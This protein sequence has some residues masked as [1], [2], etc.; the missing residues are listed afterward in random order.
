MLGSLIVSLLSGCVRT[1]L[2]LVD[3]TVP[4]PES[5]DSYYLV[6]P[7]QG[8]SCAFQL[9]FIIPIGNN[10]LWKT[11]EKVT[12]A[13]ADGLIDVSVDTS[14]GYTPLGSINC[15]QIRGL[16]VRFADPP[17]GYGPVVRAAP[18]PAI[19]PVSGAPA[20]TPQK[21][22][23][24]G[25]TLEST[26]SDAVAQAH[27]GGTFRQGIGPGVRALVPVMHASLISE[28]EFL[29]VGAGADFVLTNNRSVLVPIQ[30]RYQVNDMIGDG[31]DA[32]LMGELGLR[33]DTNGRGF[34]GGV[35]GGVTYSFSDRA[36]AMVELG[37]PAVRAG[38][39]V[40]M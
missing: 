38:V 26:R 15:T 12:P 36:S 17:A 40:D 16:A 5:T 27:L 24:F 22:E 37:F 30:A 23:A 28:D 2:Q 7:T 32:Y 10:T 31:V 33:S 20:A 8:R 9:F 11:K 19:N 25:G 6:G 1:P 29:A 39:Q 14:I 3:K 35:G 13:E 34:Y 4:L 18:L 21:A